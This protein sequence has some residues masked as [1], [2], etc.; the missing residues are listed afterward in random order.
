M[1]SKSQLETIL[2]TQI[3][4]ADLPE[5]PERNYRFD[6]V[7]R[8]LVSFA[9]TDSA[10]I[11]DLN[12][13]GKGYDADCEKQNDAEIAGWLY[14]RVTTNMVRDGRALAYIERA[15]EEWGEVEMKPTPER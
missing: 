13:R 6:P 15:L 1:K 7:K 9:F 2:A 10:I 5:K 12:T 3:Q 8:W 14:L 4:E 11:C